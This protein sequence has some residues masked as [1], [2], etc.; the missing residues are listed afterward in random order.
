MPEIEN[1]KTEKHMIKNIFGGT[2]LGYLYSILTVVSGLL[3]TPWIISCV[4]SSGHAIYTL[5]NSLISLFL[6][7]LGLSTTTSAFLSNYRAKNDDE[8]ERNFLSVAYKIYLALDVIMLGIFV[9]LYF[10]APYIYTGLSAEEI[11]QLQ[12]VFLISG[13]V[14]I[15]LFPSNVF[16]GIVT[17]HEE[18]IYLKLF[19]FC[20]KLFYIVFTAL[21]LLLNFGLFGLV[22]GNSIASILTVIFKFLVVKI[23]IKSSANWRWKAPKGFLKSVF[24]FTGWSAINALSNRLIWTV[25]PSVLGIVSISSDISAFGVVN[26]IESFFFAFSIIMSGMFL[27]KMARINEEGS[28]KQKEADEFAIK[29]SKIQNI[30]I[31]LAF[32][33]ILVCGGD[34]MTLWLEGDSE[35]SSYAYSLIHLELCLVLIP[36]IIDASQITY[37]NQMFVKG[38][39]K[40]IAITALVKGL[41]NIG[42]MFLLGYFFGNL[43]AIIS[44]AVVSLGQVIALNIIYK[45]RLGADIG[46]FY[47]SSY[48]PFLIPLALSI[49]VGLLLHFL[50]PLETIYKLII[51]AA[52]MII[53]YLPTSWFLSF[54]KEERHEFL[55]IFSRDKTKTSTEEKK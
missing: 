50:L 41:V 33:G 52:A 3:F 17:A 42:L 31:F 8:G 18:F 38:E 10:L 37:K 49:G 11:S 22:I 43:G 7:D 25:G 32:A 40:P 44:I 19:D 16:N 34:F 20:N 26:T 21:A 12:Y 1:K 39:M 24:V 14:S 9:A 6:L 46:K 47:L 53:V 28:D 55:S 27:P 48:L 2:L 54:K 29:I 13:G 5:S 15:I 35:A 4:G 45:K 51:E 36:V 23:K 30:V